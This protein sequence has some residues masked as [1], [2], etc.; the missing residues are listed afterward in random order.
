MINFIA[1]YLLLTLLGL[2]TFPLTYHLFPKFADRGYSFAR[3]VGLL[4][5]SYAFWILSTL[6]IAQNNIGGILLG[7]A[8]L[9]GLNIWS[10]RKTQSIK[11]EDTN[12]RA[13][14]LTTRERDWSRKVHAKQM[15]FKREQAQVHAR[16]G[17]LSQRKIS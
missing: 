4:I 6:G 17:T 12:L 14:A 5:W 2:L 10:F 11:D 16:S 9:V 8:A 1:W 15:L 3:V 7:L 13:K